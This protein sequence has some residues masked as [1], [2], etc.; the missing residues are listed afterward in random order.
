MAKLDE[1]SSN[2]FE[3][4]YKVVA[5]IIKAYDVV[6]R[7][8]KG[9]AKQALKNSGFANLVVDILPFLSDASRIE[10]LG[11]TKIDDGDIDTFCNLFL[12]TSCK[13]FTNYHDEKLCTVEFSLKFST[14]IGTL[15][16]VPSNLLDQI[17][18]EILTPVGSVQI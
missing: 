18:L 6:H 8:N 7:K 5:R 16:N 2:L 3:E 12:E 14:N 15:Q 13:Y 4:K 1:I 11:S 10:I 17:H 9:Y